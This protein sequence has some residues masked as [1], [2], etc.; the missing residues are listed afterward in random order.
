[1][2]CALFQM[3][4]YVTTK[5]NRTSPKWPSA[6]GEVQVPVRSEADRHESSKRDPENCNA[7]WLRHLGTCGTSPYVTVNPGT[8]PG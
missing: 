5:P 2:A 4:L 6:F 3:I 8:K 7:G 1:M